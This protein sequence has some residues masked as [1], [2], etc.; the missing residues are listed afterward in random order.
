MQNTV[1][2][3]IPCSGELEVPRPLR[4]WPST[5]RVWLWCGLHPLWVWF[6][7]HYLNRHQVALLHTEK[8]SQ[9]KTEFGQRIQSEKHAGSHGIKVAPKIKYYILIAVIIM[10]LNNWL[11]K[12]QTASLASI[13][14]A[15]DS[16]EHVTCGSGKKSL[17]M[18]DL[19]STSLLQIRAT[20]MKQSREYV[21]VRF[22]Y[23]LTEI[24]W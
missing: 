1:W 18:Q 15:R 22:V 16:W 2:L 9:R 17:Q 7:W 20:Q 12:R 21:K 3:K 19:R 8:H 14:G 5:E 11:W 10:F 4:T 6:Y 23:F 13:R 24:K